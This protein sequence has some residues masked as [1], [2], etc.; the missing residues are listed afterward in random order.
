M[1][2]A[3]PTSEAAV[4]S[5][6]N[7]SRRYYEKNREQKIA[8]S[9]KWLRNNKERVNE[10]SVKRRASSPVAY[11]LFWNAKNRAKA[12][13]IEFDLEIEDI[14]VPEVCPILGIKL[15]V[16]TG[17]AKPN[18]PSLDRVDP[19]KG[20]VRGNI[21]VLSHKA[22]TMKSNATLDELEMLVS[23]LRNWKNGKED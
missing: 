22:N 9:A 10:L 4:K 2:Y 14:E 15:V 17:N 18:S 3:D 6:R 13:E 12:K 19:N 5:R 11:V 1:P 7:A 16:A 21:Q 23:W 8:R 20:Y